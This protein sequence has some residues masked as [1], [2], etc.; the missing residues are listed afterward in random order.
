M[1]DK[2]DKNDNSDGRREPTL[3]PTRRA[4]R[5][6]SPAQPPETPDDADP[7]AEAADAETPEVESAVPA[8]PTVDPEAAAND[9]ARPDNPEAEAADLPETEAA[10][11][12]E[13]EAADL[14]DRLLRALADME[15]LR[16]RA[17][18]DR[19]DAQKYAVS[20]F[21][22][23]MLPVADNL[24][25]AI[26]SIPEDGNPESGAMASFVEGVALTEK[27]LLATLERHGISKI[28]PAA[29]EKFDPQVHEAMFEAPVPGAESG[30]VFQ[31]LETGYMIHDRLLRPAKVGVARAAPEAAGP[32]DQVDTKA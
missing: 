28:E 29:G 9:D 11:L 30:T 32:G 13:A 25:R 20:S 26:A 21:A 14:K 1:T 2:N 6:R 12:P 4:A 31:V 15:N 17:Q 7:A 5:P 8:D 10:D 22:R 19:E 24:R 23:D 16:R 3:D 18:K 27:E